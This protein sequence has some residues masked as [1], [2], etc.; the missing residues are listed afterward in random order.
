MLFLNA[1]GIR[2]SL[3]NRVLPIILNFIHL[4]LVNHYLFIHTYI[5]HCLAVLLHSALD[6]RQ[7]NPKANDYLGSINRE[8][9]NELKML[10]RDHTATFEVLSRRLLSPE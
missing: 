5:L 2:V 10:K 7:P 6:A 8:Y 9:D 3:Y 4:R 1:V